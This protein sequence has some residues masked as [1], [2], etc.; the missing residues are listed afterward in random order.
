[1][2]LPVL[3]SIY[4]IFVY[5][6]VHRKIASLARNA[7]PLPSQSPPTH[8]RGSSAAAVE[9]A[10]A[11]AVAAVNAGAGAGGGAAAAAAAGGRPEE[12]QHLRR[13]SHEADSEALELGRAGDSAAEGEVDSPSEHAEPADGTEQR[14]TMLT[15][16][17]R[18][19]M[20]CYPGCVALT[21]ALGRFW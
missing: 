7:Q 6:R 21:Q 18:Y 20:V 8:S 16:I 5:V 14:S 4:N 1:L 2:L 10:A 13:G 17:S 3:S 15:R 9:L 19:P 12:S 11:G